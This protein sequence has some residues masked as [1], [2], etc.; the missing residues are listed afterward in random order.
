MIME[1]VIGNKFAELINGNERD[2]EEF[3]KNYC[4]FFKDM[5]YDTVSYELCITRILPQAGSLKSGKA[6]PIQGRKD[7]E[8]YPW[9]ELENMYWSYAEK[10]FDILCSVLP[11]GMKAIGGIGSGAIVAIIPMLMDAGV[12]IIDPVQVTADGMAP[13]LLNEKFGGKIVFHGAIDTQQVLPN[14]TVEE[15][16][17]HCINTID[18]FG[19]S[20]GYIYAPSQIL[21]KDI[22]VENIDMIYQTI[23]VS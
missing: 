9:D 5:T 17:K 15:V 6:G 7:F 14:G 18:A 8:K 4:G 20:G 22:P 1:Q 23:S 2:I 12:D 19:D 11:E 16:K 3:F 21:N 13:A 10:K